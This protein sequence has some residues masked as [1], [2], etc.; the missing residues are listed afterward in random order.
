MTRVGVTKVI[1][2]GVSATDPG[3]T[4]L[5]L[6]AAVATGMMM[7]AGGGWAVVA[8]LHADGALLT[9][10]IFL[11]M[12]MGLTPHDATARARCATTALMYI[13]A[14]GAG[15]IATLLAPWRPVEI[16]V[17]VGVAGL[18]TWARGFGPRATALGF[19]AFF[20]YFFPLLLELTPAQLPSF[21]LV[22]AI[23]VGSL[24]LMRAI[25]IFEHPRREIDLLLRELR[26]AS[27]SAVVAAAHPDPRRRRV[28]R[29]RLARIDGV[30][31][32]IT[33]W[34]QN[35]DTARYIAAD[36][37]TFASMVLD[38]RIDVEQACAE[39]ARRCAP[40][41]G[42]QRAPADRD[43]GQALEAL[44]IVLDDR[45]APAHIDAAAERAEALLTR[46]APSSEDRALVGWLARSVL[47]HRALRTLALAGGPASSAHAPSHT[48]G[49]PPSATS[50]I[51]DASARGPAHWWDWRRWP[52]TNRLAIQVM[53]ATTL[54]TAAGEAI[55]ASHWYWAVMT[56]FIVFVGASTRGAILTRAYNRILGTAAGLLFGVTLVLLVH[57]RKPLL[58]GICVLAAFC[59]MYFGP[60][61]YLYSAFF[62]TTLL[63][64]MYGL[65][66][67][68]DTQIL[69]LRIGE[70]LVGAV[71][72][73]L[74]AYLIFSSNSRPALLAKVR[75][76][77][78]A[79]DALLVAGRAALTA[80]AR[81]ADVL[82]AVQRV[83]GAL[84]DVD[85]FTA[86]MSA[87][88]LGPRRLQRGPVV[89]L[90]YIGTRAGEAFAQSSIAVT[91]AEPARV[92]S[93]DAAA[94]LDEA[95]VRVRGAASLARSS[96]ETEVDAP[97]A[98]DT[99]IL[100]LMSR[101]PFDALSPQASAML[102][103]SRINW[104]MAQV[105]RENAR[106]R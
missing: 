31:H 76:Y 104:A 64:A 35:V 86:S 1:R 95:L 24:T 96:F 87:A 36:E 103:L 71:I 68:L 38:A 14:A 69:E 62:T 53:V 92:F 82:S 48:D 74:C 59:M 105:A 8:L 70:T 10:G 54:A 78:D 77:F 99:V 72:G 16:A 19:A 79:L 94:A 26:T 67:D 80:P 66:G 46:L 22:A 25:L 101:I 15:M 40:E 97:P 91:T 93:A 42:A 27:A 34:Q 37:T 18:G 20:G 106:G 50:P 2:R 23:T 41:A 29:K 11:A 3:R 44:E 84:S 52:L 28:L 39:L 32:A 13:P 65:L 4:R 85:A 21:L 90:L 75:A 45:A 17:L 5:K 7:S 43:V 63:V 81:D 60:L 89:H 58:V 73:V 57:D 83:G 56:A 61:L 100:D 49:L 98:H 88:M 55:S 47:A 9:V 6:A 12:Q 30:A 33:S 102:D 51:D